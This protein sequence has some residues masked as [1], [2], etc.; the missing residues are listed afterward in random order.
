M[1][2]EIEMQSS[3]LRLGPEEGEILGD[4]DTVLDRFMV[5]PESTEGRFALLEHRLAPRA[6]AAPLHLHTR[7]DEWSFVLEGSV[8]VVADGH[9]MVLGEGDL[10][11]KPRGQWHTFWNAGDGPARLL[12]LI[13][14]AGIE[15]LFRR[16]DL[17]P[18][19]MRPETLAGLAEE[20]GARV[21]FDATLS[22]MERHGL[23]F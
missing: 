21:D 12:E 3:R 19:L 6:L 11:H 9:E 16:L 5:G 4:P 14:P 7:E 22:I 8:G 15:E 18:E 20:R 1:V 13:S 23:R 10:V 2:D 17:E